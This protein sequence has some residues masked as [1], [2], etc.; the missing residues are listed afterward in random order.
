MEIFLAVLE[1]LSAL[2]LNEQRLGAYVQMIVLLRFVNGLRSRDIAVRL[3]KN[4]NVAISPQPYTM[5]TRS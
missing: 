3:S 4:E 2:N 5:N 1:K